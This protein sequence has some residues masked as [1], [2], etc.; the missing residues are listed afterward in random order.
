MTDDDTLKHYVNTVSELLVELRLAQ[1]SGDAHRIEVA[2]MKI[3]TGNC[4]MRE[5]LGMGPYTHQ[6]QA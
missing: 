6:L 2:I 3:Y 1:H 4:A 5:T